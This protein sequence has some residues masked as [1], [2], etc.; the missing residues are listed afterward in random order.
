VRLLLLLPLL[1]LACSSVHEESVREELVKLRAEVAD[2][3][4]RIQWLREE[5]ELSRWRPPG[6]PS[7]DKRDVGKAPGEMLAVA[8]LVTGVDEDLNLVL[9]SVGTEDGVA[10]GYVFRVFRGSEFV[11]TLIIDRVGPDWAAGHMKQSETKVFPRRGDDVA[12]KL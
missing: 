9:I 1:G 5:I 10:V 11:G 3:R 2:L 7:V 6:G 4:D 8:G 12:T